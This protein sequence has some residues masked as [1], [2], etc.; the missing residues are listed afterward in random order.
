MSPNDVPRTMAQNGRL[1]FGGRLRELRRSRGWTLQELG[2]RS[3]VS[4]S[5]ISKAERGIIAPSYDTI[6]KLAFAFEMDMSELLA[7]EENSISD[8]VTLERRGA[9]QTIETRHYVLDMLCS[10]RA[11]KRMVPVLARIKAHS[12]REFASF[13]RHPGEEFVFVLSGQLTFQIEGQPPRILERGDCVYFDSRLGHAYLSTGAE[14]TELL[15]TCWHPSSTD[16]TDPDDGD[17]TI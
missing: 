1:G 10:S 15:V 7:E 8:I 17:R 12:L 16:P 3:G 14:E 9:A 4:F 2:E 11:R 13:I 6:L 5:T